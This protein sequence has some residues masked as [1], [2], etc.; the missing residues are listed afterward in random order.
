MQRTQSPTWTV[1]GQCVCSDS[2]TH[3]PYHTHCTQEG[4]KE[5]GRKENREEE[6]GKEGRGREAGRKGDRRKRK[7][8][9]G[10]GAGRE[11]DREKQ[12]TESFRNK[13]F[14]GCVRNSRL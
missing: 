13:A 12:E 11:K 5:R 10:R 9:D 6:R 1:S 8:A 2:H 3:T 14:S 4:E 7:E